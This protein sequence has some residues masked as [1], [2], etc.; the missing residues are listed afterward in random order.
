M[1]IA[2]AIRASGTAAQVLDFTAAMGI[3]SGT[4]R[5]IMA[6]A[7]GNVILVNCAASSILT[8]VTQLAVKS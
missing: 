7:T 3:Q 6:D 2:V 5:L 4:T 1:R 8:N